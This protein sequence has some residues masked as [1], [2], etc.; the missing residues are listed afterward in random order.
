MS[1][2]VRKT[3][4]TMDYS[5]AENLNFVL[6]MQRSATLHAQ[7]CIEIG[8]QWMKRGRVTLDFGTT[9]ACDN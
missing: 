6:A 5:F 9:I 2:K 3:G 7:R 8:I 4:E 1:L